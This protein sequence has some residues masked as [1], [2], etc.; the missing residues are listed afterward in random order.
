MTEIALFAYQGLKLVGPLPASLQNCTSYVAL[1]W[2]SVK[3]DE[4]ARA[5]AVLALMRSL[6]GAPAHSLF[7]NAGIEPTP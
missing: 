5:D 6:Q 3:V 1:P 7:V 2:P 4:P